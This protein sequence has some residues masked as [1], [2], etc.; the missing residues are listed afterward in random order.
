MKKLMYVLFTLAL[1]IS[2]VHCQDDDASLDTIVTPTNLSID[3]T[4][5]GVDEANPKGDGSGMV[6]FQAKADRA[7]AYKFVFPD[8]TETTVTSGAVTK[9][10]TTPGLNSYKVIVVAS[11]TGGIAS[12][13][14]VELELQSDFTDP[15]TI[16]FLTGGTTKTWYW[17]ASEQGHLG[18]GA[19]NGDA[20]MNYYPNYYQATPFEKSVEGESACLYTD[21][22]VF[23]LGDGG[24]TLNYTLNN[25]G[26]TFFNAGYQSVVGGSMGFDFCYDYDTSGSKTVNLAPSESVVAANGVPSQTT[27]TVLNFTDDGFMGYYIGTS[28]YEILSITENRMVVRAILGNDNALAWYQTFTTTPVADQGGNGG[29]LEPPVYENLVWSDEFDIPGAPNPEYWSYDQGTGDNGW[30]NNESQYYT[31]RNENI[32][33]EDGFLKITAKREDYMGSAFTSARIL[34]RD[35]Q[36]FTYGRMEIRAK[37]SQGGGTWPAIWMLGANF[38]EVGWPTT[39]EIDIMEHVGNAPTEILSTLHF[40]GNSGG[41]GVTQNVEVEGVEEDFHTYKLIWSPESMLFYVDNTLYHTFDNRADLPFNKDFFFIL[42]VAM[43]GNLG[44]TIDP[45]F[46]SSQMEVDYVRVYQ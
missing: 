42:N 9:R 2:M 27:G 44:G 24:E 11:G 14:S 28:S 19:N 31:E 4:I 34:T 43:G 16:Q 23:S 33:V 10:F 3:Y 37:L 45:A 18:V 26:S 40:P 30:G 32:I 5:Q 38:E 8:G 1:S 36:E 41:N 39:G 7:I 25:N 12:T 21:E 13:N 17:A 6:N 22:L 15:N 35:K 29:D 20:T 46:N